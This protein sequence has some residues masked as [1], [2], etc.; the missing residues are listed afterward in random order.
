MTFEVRYEWWPRRETAW[1]LRDNTTP[2]PQPQL[3][4]PQFVTRIM[5]TTPTARTTCRVTLALHL[6]L[7]AEGSQP[8]MRRMMLLMS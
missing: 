8:R 4:N 1:F 2:E 5:G 3:S 6:G 7:L